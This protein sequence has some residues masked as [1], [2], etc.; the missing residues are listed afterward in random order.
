MVLPV[1]WHDGAGPLRRFAGKA[2]SA[3]H[4]EQTYNHLFQIKLTSQSSARAFWKGE[5][6]RLLRI[7]PD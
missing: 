7:L 4:S 6:L 5:T 3:F 2:M 1:T